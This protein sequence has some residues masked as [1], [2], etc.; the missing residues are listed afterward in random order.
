MNG[1]H[2][3]GD[4]DKAILRSWV[5]D[6]LE[7]H[8]GTAHLLDV[9]RY[10]WQVHEHDLRRMG[11]LFYTWQYDYRWAATQL[12]KQGVLQEGEF[13]GSGRWALTQSQA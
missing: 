12:R 4:G 9:A 5:V 13:R 11:D 2:A 7:H 3:E 1:Q 10:I 6:A 8:G